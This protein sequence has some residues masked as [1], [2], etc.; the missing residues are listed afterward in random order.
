MYNWMLWICECVFDNSM[1]NIWVK[2]ESDR[3][4]SH[5]CAIIRLSGDHPEIWKFH[6]IEISMWVIENEN[7]GRILIYILVGFFLLAYRIFL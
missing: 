5:I 3:F 4:K 6:F 1:E 7:F 2:I